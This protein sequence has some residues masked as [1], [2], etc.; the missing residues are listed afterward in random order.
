MGLVGVL[1]LLLL[2]IWLG[3][4]YLLVCGIVIGSVVYGVGIVC[5]CEEG[6]I[7]G[8]VSSIGMGLGVVLVILVVVL[9]V[10]LV[11]C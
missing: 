10:G 6:S 2:L 7:I 1:I 8:V 4:W 11:V 5:V 3:V 9:L